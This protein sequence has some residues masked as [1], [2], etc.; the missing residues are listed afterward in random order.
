MR[1]LFYMKNHYVFKSYQ[2][3]ILTLVDNNL[4]LLYKATLI[5]PNFRTIKQKNGFIVPKKYNFLVATEA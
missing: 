5:I 1:I 3:I 2:S 4:I